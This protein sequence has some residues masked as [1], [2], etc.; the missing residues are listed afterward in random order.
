MFCY[1]RQRVLRKAAEQTVQAHAIDMKWGVLGNAKRC[2][3]YLLSI[4]NS[5]NL[6]CV[7]TSNFVDLLRCV[8]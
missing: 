6:S 7:S 2:L 1:Q 5:D 4:N 3:N 8:D